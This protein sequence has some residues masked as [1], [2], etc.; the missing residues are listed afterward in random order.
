MPKIDR[1]DDPCHSAKKD[2]GKLEK[3]RSGM[4]EPKGLDLSIISL[5]RGSLRSG[6][7]RNLR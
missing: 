7:V 2:F 4:L 3:K 1:E 6:V 5:H